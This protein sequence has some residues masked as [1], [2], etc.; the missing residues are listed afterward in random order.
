MSKRKSIAL[1]GAILGGTLLIG[2]TFASWIVTDNADPFGIQI[3]PVA[4]EESEAHRVTLEW[5]AEAHT[6]FT[7]ISD[8]NLND[9]IKRTVGL[10]A[11]YDGD[12]FT[13]NLSATLTTTS[14]NATKLIDYLDVDVYDKENK[15]DDG[16]TKLFTISH[17]AQTPTYSGNADIAVNNNV[18]KVVSFYFSLNAAMT[19]QI[20]ESV[21]S[22]TVT[23]TI[24][25][26]KG[27]QIVAS[28]A[29]TYYFEPLSGWNVG[30]KTLYAYAWTATGAINNAWPG[31]AMGKVKDAANGHQ[32]IY[33]ITLEVDAL[34]PYTHIIFTDNDGHQ[35]ADLDL[36]ASTP[37]Y[38]M[39]GLEPS[40][41]AAP[42]LNV[43]V[44][45]YF[46]AG[47]F[48]A[49]AT[50]NDQ[51]QLVA[52]TVEDDG[53]ADYDYMLLAK[54]IAAGQTL[55]VISSTG[56]WYGEHGT[57]DGNFTI[58]EANTYDFF[59]SVNGVNGV[60]I[61]CRATPNP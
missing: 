42:D 7:N 54:D 51:W 44:P 16:A 6:T 28:T 37:Y 8:I 31:I 25:W 36:N 60:F 10:K 30:E 53:Y 46:I 20:Y 23:I 27:S 55:K 40:W 32:P 35:T 9:E 1:V 26:N 47:S 15:T 18:E 38:S 56:V 61:A 59:F 33:A 17:H 58:G 22:D 39:Y 3:T 4:L 5:G 19:P 48:N 49:W 34:D 57:S 45:D 21:R 13:G 43:V 14:N 24:D 11:V 52:N 50:D 12:A 2:G 29:Q 41:Q